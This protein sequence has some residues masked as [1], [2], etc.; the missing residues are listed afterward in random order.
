MWAKGHMEQG[1]KRLSVQMPEAGP[2][3]PL[4]ELTDGSAGDGAGFLRGEGAMGMCVGSHLR[5]GLYRGVPI[6]N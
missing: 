1:S 2:P 5:S 4:L 3:I 6:S